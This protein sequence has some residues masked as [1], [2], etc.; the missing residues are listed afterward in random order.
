MF[1]EFSPNLSVK[2]WKAFYLEEVFTIGEHLNGRPEAPHL[3]SAHTCGEPPGWGC[4]F[5]PRPQL[6]AHFFFR[7]NPSIFFRIKLQLVLPTDTHT[8]KGN[9]YQSIFS[10]LADFFF[11]GTPGAHFIVSPDFWWASSSSLSFSEVPGRTTGPLTWGRRGVGPSLSLK[12][13]DICGKVERIRHSES[14]P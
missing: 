7:T 10:I 5:C 11:K 12:K 2:I 13:W 1:L 3:S 8:H 4:F 6:K 14:N 9:V